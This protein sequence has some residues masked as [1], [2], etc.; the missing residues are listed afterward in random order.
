MKIAALQ[1]STLPMSDVKL[2]YYFKIC[3]KQGVNLLLLSE[4]ALNSF[5]K[6]LEQMPKSM[7]K[8]QSNHKI[9]IL[10]N[11]CIE[12]DINV[13]A[14]IV[15]IK[16]EHLYKSTARFSPRSVHFYDQQFLINYKHWNEERFFDNVLEKFSLPIFVLDGFRFAIVNGYELHFDT[17]WQEVMR[18]N[19]DVVLMSSSSTFDSLQRW[20]ELIKSRAFLNNVYILRANR[21]GSYKEGAEAWRFYGHSSLTSPFGD[22]ELCLGDKEEIL[23]ASV[24]K[25]VVSEARKMWG[26]KKQVFKREL[27]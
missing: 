12:Y 14:P 8:E 9:Q 22:I 23:V 26:W 27:L 13:V 11:L 19:I 6:E 3:K 1:L 5:F 15:T 2:D 17:V 7:I 10:K 21:I 18:K 4:Y 16:G 24:D 20:Q 25:D